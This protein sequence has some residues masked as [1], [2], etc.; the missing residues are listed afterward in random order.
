MAFE[1]PPLPYAYDALEPTINE[2]TMKFHHDRHHKAYT[3][4][5]NEGVEKDP[6]LAGKTIEEILG[7]IST[8]PPLVRNNGGGFWNHD[9]FWK[10]MTPGG[11]TPSGKLAAAIEAFGGLDKLKEEFN[12]KGAGQFGS[13]WAWVIADASGAL[14]VTS[15]PN[16]DNPLMDDAKDKGTPI[17]GNDVWEH[18]YYLTY[19]NDRAAYLKSWWDVVNWDEAGKR[20]DA[21]VG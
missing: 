9:F 2:E 13:G 17:L 6:A 5:L 11:G 14:K 3:D 18:A 8:Q 12:T 4:K 10:I 21:A 20:Y 16:Q 1:L 19:R 15:T 7:V